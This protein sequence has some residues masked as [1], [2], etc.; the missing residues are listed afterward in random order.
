M[1]DEFPRACYDERNEIATEIAMLEGGQMVADS[2][3]ARAVRIRVLRRVLSRL[4]VRSLTTIGK[5]EV[6]AKMDRGQE[7][8]SELGE[9]D[10]I[11]RLIKDRLASAVAAGI[12][13]WVDS[14][15]SALGRPIYHVTHGL[16]TLV[17]S[18]LGLVYDGPALPFACRYAEIDHIQLSAL[19]APTQ[20]PDELSTI[21]IVLRDVPEGLE[22]HL[23]LRIYTD[24]AAVLTGVVKALS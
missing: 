12:G 21:Q 24:V 18:Q 7:L 23:P 14:P 3:Q 9:I 17:L 22:M 11:E 20:F 15:A 6:R 4:T 16:V 13:Q 5:V 8:S 1:T 19:D 2:G 10:K